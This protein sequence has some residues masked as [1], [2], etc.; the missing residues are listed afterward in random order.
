MVGAMEAHLSGPL[1]HGVQAVAASKNM[2]GNLAGAIVM[3]F[4]TIYSFVGHRKV[5]FK[6]VTTK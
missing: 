5:T 6:P 2:A 1:L 4:T 3:G